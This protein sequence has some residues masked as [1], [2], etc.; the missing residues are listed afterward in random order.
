MTSILERRLILWSVLAPALLVPAGDAPGNVLSGTPQA[1]LESNQHVAAMGNALAAADVDGDGLDDLVVAAARYDED[2]VDEDKG[3]VFVFTSPVL[4][5]DPYSAALLVAGHEA[6]I[7]LGTSVAFGDLDD[8]G[9]VDLAIGA[10]G[11]GS[12]GRVYVFFGSASGFSG[13]A[14]GPAIHPELGIPFL[15]AAAADVVLESDRPVGVFNL[16]FGTSLVVGDFDGDGVDDLAVGAP[17]YTNTLSAGVD[18]E[19]VVVVFH[20]ATGFAAGTPRTAA[21]LLAGGKRIA[22]F[23]EALGVGDFNGDGIDD[24]AV[25]AQR[26][27]APRLGGGSDVRQAGAVFVFHGASPGGIPDGNADS[28]ASTI[29]GDQFRGELGGSLASAGDLNGDGSDDLLVGAHL[30]DAPEQNEGAAFL[31]L[32]AAPAPGMAPI[33]PSGR[34][35]AAA[36]VFQGD[37]ANH[38]FGFRI[39]GAD[40]NDDGFVDLLIAAPSLTGALAARVYLFLGSA[41]GFTGGSPATADAGLALF[42]A[43]FSGLGSALATADFDGDGF[44]DVAAGAPTDEQG[45]LAIGDEGTVSI[46]FGASAAPANDPPVAVGDHPDG[47]YVTAAGMPLT[48]PIGPQGVL[49]NDFD[50]ELA[51]LAAVLDT[52]TRHGTLSFTAGSAEFTYTPDPGFE[53]LDSFTYHV[54]DGLSDSLP[55]VVVIRV[56]SGAPPPP[57]GPPVAGDD[58]YATTQDTQLVVGPPGVLANDADPD[59]DPLAAALETGPANGAVDVAATGAVTYTPNPG[60]T[61]V[62]TFTYR[63]S[64][65]LATSAPAVVTIT[66]AAANRPPVAGDDAYTLD[67]DT[68]LTVPAAGVLGND[69]DPEADPLTAVLVTPPAQGIVDLAADGSFVYTPNADFFGTDSFTYVA[70]DGAG[71]SPPATVTLSVAQVHDCPEPGGG[72]E[73]ELPVDGVLEVPPPGLL[74][75]ARNP[76]LRPLVPV[77]LVPPSNGSLTLLPGG[78]FR[79]LPNPGFRGRDRFV[80]AID[81]GTDETGCGDEE[82]LAAALGAGPRRAAARALSA[83]ATVEL[84]V[85]QS[86][87]DVP[88]LGTWGALLLV[89]ALAGASWWRLRAG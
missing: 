71:A 24:L 17:G 81:D 49:T 8:D 53:G 61:G 6:G 47:A 36:A 59:G 88:A 39:A 35:A 52:T 29:L 40:V 78:G 2:G 86:V 34:P 16:P 1:Q 14:G 55:A 41:T 85:G 82:A 28:A 69:S 75:D 58:A 21:T 48:V 54:N 73:F 5:R 32:T 83:P 9:F 20:G 22:F 74:R 42:S 43:V 30:Y 63:A 37:S 31:F 7:L 79:Y 65:G 72:L 18:S 62:D 80:F 51:P 15:T 46:Y 10:P 64:D 26:F 11:A 68:V 4:S 77:L 84:V 45:T 87:V 13:A 66:V 89:L 44:D 19:G 12:G 60:F 33:V 25:G 27:D 67:E 56:G 70:S 3:A 76:D 57:N 50:P 23:G 38:V